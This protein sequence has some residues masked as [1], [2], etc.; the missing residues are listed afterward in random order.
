MKGESVNSQRTPSITVT[1]TVGIVLV[2]LLAVFSA[3]PAARSNA[4]NAV[5]EVSQLSN[6][7]SS[8]LARPFRLVL[9]HS[10]TDHI[11]SSSDV[12]IGAMARLTV[13]LFKGMN[14]V[15]KTPS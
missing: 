12:T 6:G 2:S 13:A 8:E 3:M 15:V 1:V 5:V 10:H 14:W 11:P 4:S 7:L 9:E